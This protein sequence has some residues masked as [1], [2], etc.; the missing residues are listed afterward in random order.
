[1]LKKLKTSIETA[2][3]QVIYLKA[4]QEMPTS[5]DQRQITMSDN[6]FVRRTLEVLW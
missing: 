3:D 1:M 6:S 4:F 2:G 5:F